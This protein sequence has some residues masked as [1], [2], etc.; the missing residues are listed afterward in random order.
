GKYQSDYRGDPYSRDRA[1]HNGT[2]WAWLIGPFLDAYLAVNDRSPQ[3]RDQARTWLRP[4]IDHLETGCVGHISEIF[5]ADSPHRAVGCP[6]QAWSIA[7]VL[8]LAVD[9]D[10]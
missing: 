9:L 7:E 5:D 10:M 2:V 3:A 4:L 8:R 6:A 1:Y